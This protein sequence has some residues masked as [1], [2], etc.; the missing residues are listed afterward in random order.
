MSEEGVDQDP[1]TVAL[2]EGRTIDG[3]VEAEVLPRAR[4]ASREVATRGGILKA[5]LEGGFARR[6]GVN[7]P[8]G[9]IF[10]EVLKK[11]YFIPFSMF[12]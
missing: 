8:T 5:G 10:R 9:L 3:E 11:S 12:F 4:R 1:V 7:V 6:D 2:E